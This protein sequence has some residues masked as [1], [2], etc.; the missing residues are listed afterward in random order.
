MIRLSNRTR[1][2]PWSQTVV[3]GAALG[4]LAVFF[5][6]F[7]LL[8][9]LEL[10]A[11]DQRFI[12]R[13]NNDPA[14]EVL[15]VGITD[16]CLEKLG[17]WP[18]DRDVHGRLLEVLTEGKAAAV[19]M[20]ILFSEPSRDLSMDQAMITATKAA[21]EAGVPVIY[22]MEASP[23][24]SHL[25]GFLTPRSLRLPIPELMETAKAGYINVTPDQ[26]GIL[27]KMI[28]WMEY[29]GWPITSFNVL[30]W[31]LSQGVTTDELYQHLDELFQPNPTNLP[32][33]HFDF[34]LDRGGR[35]LINY[36]GGPGSFPVLPYHLVA[37]GA[38]PPSTFDNALVL[39]G[40]YAP[41]LG[42]YYFTPFAKDQPMYGIEVHANIVNTLLASGPIAP[43]SLP[44]NLS[45]AFFLGFGSIFL[46]QAVRPLWG[47]AC[48]AALTLAFYLA[49][50]ILFARHGIYLEAVY[51]LLAVIGSYL[52]ALVYN[53]V[54]EQRDRQRVT[55][56]FGRY[57]A[58]QVVEEILSVGE[59]NLRLGGTK[60][61]V[62]LLFIDI[63]GFTPLSE[64]LSPEEVVKVL[65][66]YFE[67]VTRSIFENK[68][69]VDKFM[70]DAAMALF[71]A[72][73]PLEDHAL[74]AVKAAKAIT[75]E[76]AALQQRVL[77]MSGVTLHFG[78]GINTGEA[79]VGNIG[80]ENRMEYTAIG[81]AVNLA[82]RL[83]SNA[84]PG[85]VLVS[86]TVYQEVA[87]RLPLE[88]VGEIQVK[89]K[90]QPVMVYQLVKYQPQEPGEEKKYSSLAVCQYEFRK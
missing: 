63:R 53:F 18:W 68:G 49:N 3:M 71:N 87:G 6:Y 27:R 73:L 8:G 10:A 12:L 84:K 44:A 90:S 69:T 79:I 40:F 81:D 86:E 1:P 55:R 23:E 59:E 29:Q 30:L 78:I 34:P 62:T 4:L 75:E 56:L 15:I 77:E 24:I 35:T 82:A 19:G 70:G 37:E 20:D 50:S 48:L 46:Y 88:P 32:L 76:G 16:D 74:W 65:N 80:S 60:R 67:M 89:G 13:G 41:G 64:K 85:Q 52:T 17:R 51:P 83:E 36:A 21:W 54:V 61:K 9:S 72:P 66:E 33:G 5:S 14:P 25:P 42:D 57:V 58:P 11:Y 43:L 26:D 31:A 7:N 45:I 39:V 38:Y 47:F 28:L 2:F 22:A